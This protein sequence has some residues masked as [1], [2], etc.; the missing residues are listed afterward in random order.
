MRLVRH[1]RIELYATKWHIAKG[2]GGQLTG[3]PTR[4]RK[5]TEVPPRSDY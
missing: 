3:I 2:D 1:L 5:T 4:L